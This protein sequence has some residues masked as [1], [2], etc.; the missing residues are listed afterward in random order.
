M[1]ASVSASSIFTHLPREDVRF[2]ADRFK[3]ARRRAGLSRKA[4]VREAGY[5]NIA[6]GLRRLD[7][8]EHPMEPV[9]DERVLER[10]A[11]VL[12]VDLDSLRRRLREHHRAREMAELE[13][14]PLIL[15]TLLGRARESRGL[16]PDQVA[17]RATT[18]C[19]SLESGDRRFPA[20]DDLRSLCEVLDLSVDRARDARSR[21]FA[22]YD[23]M[24]GRPEAAARLV[25][26]ILW[27]F[28][29]PDGLSTEELVAFSH[30][31]SAD[32][33]L[34]VYVGLQDGRCIHI[35]PGGERF[36]SF[37]PPR[38]QLG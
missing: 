24:E 20:D 30:D 15:G 1:P 22:Y 26:A 8:L 16:T 7:N 6:K 31:L 3:R 21:E 9:P 14:H 34:P 10:F 32:K 11:H 4:C 36:E 29:H 2:L 37:S 17:R 25:G 38:V 5:T 28:D 18:G 23:R 33:D 12:D 13:R 19:R 27:G 35:R